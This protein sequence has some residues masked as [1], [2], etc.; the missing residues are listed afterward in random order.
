[1]PLLLRDFVDTQIRNTVEIPLPQQSSDVSDLGVLDRLPIDVEQKRHGSDRHLSCQRKKPLLEPPCAASSAASDSHLHPVNATALAIHS[2]SRNPQIAVMLGDIQIPQP[3]PRLI[4]G[5]G[6]PLSTLAAPV[7]LPA[8]FQPKLDPF[9]SMPFPFCN[10]I[11]LQPNK[12]IE[13]IGRGHPLA[14]WLKLSVTTTL[15]QVRGMLFYFMKI[16]SFSHYS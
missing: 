9:F 6:E 13:P 3:N 5:F 10:R 12:R 16:F 7:V 2:D 11:A 14:F 4:E 8:V 15:Y 1:M